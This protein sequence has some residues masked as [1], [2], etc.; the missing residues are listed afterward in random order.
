MQRYLNLNVWTKHSSRPLVEKSK[1]YLT[2]NLAPKCV[3]ELQVA[4]IIRDIVRAI[5]L[6]LPTF[7]IP[8]G[9]YL[10]LYKS[11]GHWYK[12]APLRAY[13]LAVTC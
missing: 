4:K 6:F 9:K 8:Q 10:S 7:N 13:R 12:Y 1:T 5:S 11:D 2:E 3:E